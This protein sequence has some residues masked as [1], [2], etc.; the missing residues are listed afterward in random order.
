LRRRPT[1][2]VTFLVKGF[3][4]SRRGKVRK[5]ITESQEKWV[6]VERSK[7]SSGKRQGRADARG[8]QEVMETEN[9]KKEA[10]VRQKESLV[11][12]VLL[13]KA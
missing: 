13:R 5:E 3:C 10:V 8:A 12:A 7:N 2:S 4:P 11:K 9:R 6:S 1:A